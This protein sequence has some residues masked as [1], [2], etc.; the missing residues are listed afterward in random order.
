MASNFLEQARDG[1]TQA[2]A[3][4]IDR[5][6]QK[7][8]IQSTV[9]LVTGCLEVIL[10]AAQAPDE[11]IAD[12]IFNGLL[13]LNIEPAHKAIIYGRAEGEYFATW[14]QAFQLKAAPNYTSSV[15]S[16]KM[17]HSTDHPD[18]HS[19]VFTVNDANGKALKIDVAQIIGIT[20]AALVLLGVFTPIVSLPVVGT[21]SL[22]SNGSENG[23]AV[24]SLAIISIVFM[25]KG[26]YPWV[27]GTGLGLLLIVGGVFAQ[28]S[29]AIAAVKSN[30]DREL[31]GNPFRGLA[32]AAM[33]AVQLQWGWV[34]L[35][36]GIGMILTA[37]YL[38]KPRLNRQAFVSMGAV[39]AGVIVLT[40]LKFS[41][42]V[43]SSWGAAA[44]ARQSEAQTYIGSINRGQ[45]AFYLEN[46]GFAP[47]L[48]DLAM[49]IPETLGK[50]QYAVSVTEKDMTIATATA[51][52]GGLKSITGA[53]FVTEV[54]GVGETTVSIVCLSNSSTQTPPTVP[55]LNSAGKPQ[56]SSGSASK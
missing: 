45:Q 7:H 22:F 19:W 17:H 4:L 54:E 20:G 2:I 13:K 12:S 56:C 28:L 36:L 44:K 15:S 24:L 53:V 14:S 6:L 23:I 1:D 51:T 47:T 38:K 11:T 25:V 52:Q 35:F 18:N 10:D 48:A 37:A 41:V 16:E 42:T 39:L 5:S 34:I 46:S 27:Y 55:T 50:Y 21:L 40:G 49:G 3:T 32:D 43:I 30:A 33:A 8:S 9:T 31:S 26:I 29:S